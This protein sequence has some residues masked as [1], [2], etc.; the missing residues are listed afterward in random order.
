MT[1]EEFKAFWDANF[2]ET[3]PVSHYFRH[4]YPDRW[5]R[6]HSLPQSKRYPGD[7]QEWNILLNRQNQIIT[8]LIGENENFLL[9]TGEHTQEG[10]TELHPLTE[11]DS[12]AQIP[13]ILLEKIDLHQVSPDVYETGAF[14]H[15]M[16]S[17]QI[18]IPRKFDSLLRD[19]AEDNLRVI[20]ISIE[21]ELMIAPY[22]GGVDFILKN[23]PALT[24][25]AIA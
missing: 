20:F 7:D 1:A 21:K 3:I 11:A 25:G 22:D 5:F 14:Y 10:Y 6:I 15:P 23:S 17:E 2:P 9:V 4:D 19:M 18:W 12:I 13:F 24:N 16:F 8:D